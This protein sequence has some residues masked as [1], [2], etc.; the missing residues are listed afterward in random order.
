M[1]ARGE[2][3]GG[4]FL[5]IATG[6]QYAVPEAVTSLRALRR[7]AGS[8]AVLV[9][10]AWDPLNLTGAFGESRRIPAI[11]GHRIA[12]RDGIPVAVRGAGRVQWLADGL[13]DGE[14]WD[15]ELALVRGRAPRAP[16]A[17]RGSTEPRR[18][19]LS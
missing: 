16:P 5:A 18:S 6:E 1:E 12:L 2:L 11:F 14:R 7:E 8:G 3:R 15:L 19:V 4:R 10:S 17:S 9:L 13:G